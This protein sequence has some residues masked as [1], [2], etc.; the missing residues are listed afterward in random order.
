M[1]FSCRLYSTTLGTAKTDVKVRGVL[2]RDGN[3]FQVPGTLAAKGFGWE[4][5]YATGVLSAIAHNGSSL[6]TTAVTFTA[7][8]FR[9]YDI[10]CYYDGAGT[11]SIYVNGTLAGTATGGPTGVASATNIWA[12]W[13]IEN[14]STSSAANTNVAMYNPKVMTTF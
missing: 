10:V 13:E 14:T 3:A 5:N 6:T 12:Q 9:S 2:G 1:A 4:F 11:V 7:V 8:N